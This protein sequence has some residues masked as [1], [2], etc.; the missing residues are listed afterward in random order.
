MGNVYD[1]GKAFADKNYQLWDDQ[2]R[3]PELKPFYKPDSELSFESAVTSFTGGDAIYN[4]IFGLI[5]QSTKHEIASVDVQGTA[6]DMIVLVT[7]RVF[8]DGG[9]GPLYF[10]EAFHLRTSSAGRQDSLYILRDI[11]R[12]TKVQ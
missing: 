5:P 2:A 9:S 10:S 3:R 1:I 4:G 11:I 8:L 6:D 12:V 7:G